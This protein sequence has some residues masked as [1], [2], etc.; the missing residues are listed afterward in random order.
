MLPASSRVAARLLRR[1]QLPMARRAN[2]ARRGTHPPCRVNIES[3][4][5]ATSDVHISSPCEIS[6]GVPAMSTTLCS[7]RSF[8]P[9]PR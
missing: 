4:D 8:A 9:L 5:S 3:A 7:G 6:V 2:T 1:S